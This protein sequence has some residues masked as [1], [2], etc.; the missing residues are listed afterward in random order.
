MLMV[1]GQLQALQSK[2]ESARAAFGSALKQ[3]P[4]NAVIMHVSCRGSTEEQ[5]QGSC[6]MR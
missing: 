2:M 5:S 4:S 3:E 6:R 1:L